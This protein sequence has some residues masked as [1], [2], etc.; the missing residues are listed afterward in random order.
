[1][2]RSFG[3]A[4]AGFAVERSRGSASVDPEDCRFNPAHGQGIHLVGGTVAASRGGWQGRLL[5]EL[6]RQ[7]GRSL[8]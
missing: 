4:L 3:T 6:S 8:R 1:M 5:S 7:V 2:L